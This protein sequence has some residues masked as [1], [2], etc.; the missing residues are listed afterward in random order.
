VPSAVNVDGECAY[1]TE[2]EFKLLESAITFVVP[3]GSAFLNK[4]I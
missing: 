2:R 4:S 3:R 1:V